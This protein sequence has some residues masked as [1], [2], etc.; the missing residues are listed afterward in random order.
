MKRLCFQF[1]L[2]PAIVATILVMAVTS[3]FGFH[4]AIC[5]PNWSTAK[6]A[7]AFRAKAIVDRFPFHGWPDNR[8]NI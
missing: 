3:V 4:N 1:S 5:K 6:P 8:R 7:T 2:R